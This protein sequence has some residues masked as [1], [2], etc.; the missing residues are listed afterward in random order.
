MMRSA[1]LSPDPAHVARTALA[2]GAIALDA[3][4][5]LERAETLSLTDDLTD[6]PNQRFFRRAVDSA[7]ATAN[8]GGPV[9]LLLLDLDDFKSVNDRYGH[10]HGDQVLVETAG[11]LRHG[12]RRSDLVARVGG[13]EFAV[14]LPATGRTGAAAVAARLARRVA[15]H[16][17]PSRGSC[18]AR[19]TVSIGT[20]TTVIEAA[21]G[22]TGTA[23]AATGTVTTPGDL[24]P[25]AFVQL[26]DDALYRAKDRR[27]SRRARRMKE[28]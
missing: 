11:L 26:A 14:L 5:R 12:T 3:A 10:P 25:G 21:A 4:R 1:Q 24:S 2:L 23:A 8:G 15:G 17:F 27:R 16:R 18:A 20:A 9:S 22:S 19:V 6:L 28:R 13:D 7:L